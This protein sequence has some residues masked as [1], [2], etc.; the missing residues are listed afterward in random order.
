MQKMG[1]AKETIRTRIYYLKRLIELEA[2]LDK[3]STLDTIFITSKWN[4]AYKRLF[5]DSYKAYTIYKGIN[6]IKPK[7]RIPEKEPFLP[8]DEEVK[9]LIAGTGK[10][11]S[12]LL[13]L[14]Y[15]TGIRIGEATAIKWD[16]INFITKKIRINTPEKGSNSR[17]LP[18]SD[19]LISC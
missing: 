14:L 1:L 18:I 16:A 2:N 9:Q 13:Q 7:I 4:P 3:P 19:T 8:E 12:T 10:T 6:W 11:T 5:I 15:E 17:T